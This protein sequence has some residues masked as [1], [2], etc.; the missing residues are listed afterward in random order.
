MMIN[1]TTGYYSKEKK[2]YLINK[3]FSDNYDELKMICH[4]I[5][6]QDDV[7]D[8]LHCCIE[9]FI[10]NK[11]TDTLSDKEK[12]Y[13]FTKIVKNNFYSKTSQFYNEYKKFK[14]SDHIESN[15][16]D[17]P[18]DESPISMDWVQRQITE[19]K[20]GDLWYYSRLFE[21]FIEGG[22]SIT[23]LS[24]KTTIPINSVSR[25]IN[26]YRRILKQL[27]KLYLK[28]N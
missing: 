27:R 23:N 3:W 6:K 16:T 1:S 7:D 13:F 28:N 17:E 26:K 24:K 9:Q 15:T 11:N 19:H 12:L 2:L 18:Y 25:D 14:F 5:S 8:L 22:C 10:L 20:K 4:K 21:L